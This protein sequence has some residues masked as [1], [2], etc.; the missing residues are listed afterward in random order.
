M[1]CCGYYACKSYL[2]ISCFTCLECFCGKDKCSKK[3]CKECCRCIVCFPCDCLNINRLYYI[4]EE[5]ERCC[6]CCCY[7]PKEG[8]VN[9]YGEK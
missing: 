4:D 7:C 5:N 3:S 8:N 6:Y 2:N 1:S 9:F